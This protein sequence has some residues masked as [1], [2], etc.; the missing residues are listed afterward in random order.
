MGRFEQFFYQVGK[1]TEKGR[2]SPIHAF[3]ETLYASDPRHI[4]LDSAPP[5]PALAPFETNRPGR[6]MPCP[7]T[8][9]EKRKASS[10]WHEN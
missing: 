6:R 3:G 5:I 9:K 10:S 2:L 7:G 1:N 4:L 8:S